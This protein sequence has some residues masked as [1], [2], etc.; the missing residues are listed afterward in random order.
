MAWQA[1]GRDDP[2]TTMV[3]A[4]AAWL[5][6]SLA[7]VVLA[8]RAGLARDVPRR[9]RMAWMILAGAFG[10]TVLGDGIWF[11]FE[12]V[13]D[14]SPFPS[15]ADIPYLSFY[16]VV[17]VGLL[18]FPVA[19]RSRRERRKLMF[20]VGT[21]F[22]A[23]S[24]AVWYLVLGPT[25]QDQQSDS[26]TAML[27]MAYP[28]GDIVLLFGI[29]ALIARGVD[30]GSERALRLLLAG[31]VCY[32]VADL[33]FGY[34]SLEGT[35]RSGDWPDTLW[36]MASLAFIV[37]AWRQHDGA[38]SPSARKVAR[39]AAPRI[40]F[41]P[42]AAIAAVWGMVLFAA[43]QEP[44]F[45]LLGLL[46]GGLSLTL[47]V[48]ARQVV[49]VNENTEL[50]HLYQSL[51]GTDSLTGLANRRRFFDEADSVIVTCLREREPVSML[52]IDVDHFK[53][54]NDTLGHL[55]GD[56]ALQEVANAL[57][58]ALRDDDMVARL[59]GDEFAIVLPRC[60]SL[61]ADVVST[62]LRS[63]VA[64]MGGAVSISIGMVTAFDG[65][66]DEFMRQADLALYEA[67]RSGRDGASVYRPS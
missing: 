25:A 24:M 20:D 1:V 29:A 43:R 17:L 12:V 46:V 58:A 66:I 34:L 57:S 53:E 40:N 22:V 59:G 2:H 27:S 35:Y 6:M 47:L 21:V 13:R 56:Q 54:I 33:A 19:P 61:E 3:V 38:C 65:D 11:V 30:A 67:K 15:V 4:D 8:L 5:P 28:V 60:D 41:L 64:M 52:M 7:A 9:T 36:M 55:A 31:V 26:F 32:V 37:S 50:V 16:P 45:P 18:M 62:R 14:Q 42:Y 44:I 48:F 49:A 51:A 39:P 10:L 23:G 63:G